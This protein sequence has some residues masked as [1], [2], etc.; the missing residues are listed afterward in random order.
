MS[1]DLGRLTRL[2][3][4][5]FGFESFRFGQAE[6]AVAVMAKKNVFVRMK[7]SGGKS[8]CYV[9]PALLLSGITLVVSPLISLMEDQVRHQ[10][11]AKQWTM[12]LKCSVEVASLTSRGV[13]SARVT[14]LNDKKLAAEIAAG[15]HRLGWHPLL[16]GLKLEFVSVPSLLCLQCTYHRKQQPPSFGKL[17]FLAP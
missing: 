10:P 17:C 11:T 9:L 5:V 1:D 6:A 4:D 16:C 14:S 12:A 7:T 13:K 15:E 8:L 2:L 3:R